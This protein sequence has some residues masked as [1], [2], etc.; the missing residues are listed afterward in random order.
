[1]WRGNKLSLIMRNRS[2]KNDP[3]YNNNSYNNLHYLIYFFSLKSVLQI[4]VGTFID[5]NISVAVQTQYKIGKVVKYKK[6]FWEI[7]ITML[8][9]LNVLVFE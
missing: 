8:V 5:L 1:M 3:D 4:G 9:C 6:G 2:S 7:I